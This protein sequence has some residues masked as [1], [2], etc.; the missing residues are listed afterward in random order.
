ALQTENPLLY[1]SMAVLAL[2]GPEPRVTLA[3]E[4]GRA[5][6]E[7]DPFLLPGLVDRLA[8]FALTD[9]QWTALVPPSPVDHVDLARHLESRGLLHE[10][11]VLYASALEGASAAEEP[12]IRWMLARLLLGVHRPA[13][14]MVQ[15]DA[16]LAKSSGNPEL[17]LVRAQALEALKAPGSLNAY[18]AAVAS[19]EGRSG[20]VF[21]TE[22]PRL[23]AIAAERLGR[24]AR[25]SPARY[26]RAL[27]QRLT[28][29]RRWEAARDEWERAGTDGPL[30]AQGE[31]SRGLA[32]EATGDPARALEAFRQAATLDPT[33]TAFRARLATRLWENDQYMQAIAEWQTIAGLEPGNVE[34]HLALA[35]AY[36]KA[37]DRGRALGEYRRVLV[38]APGHAE[39]RQSVARLSGIP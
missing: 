28:D 21:P 17:L 9:A 18:R 15:A 20:L 23:Q 5:A 26:R 4:A 10:A 14:A 16:A 24:D 34:A 32:L 33:R 30:D 12:V 19:A 8:P 37:G 3:L 2:A 22:S 7:R 6:A 27:A 31:F 35:R 11:R 29:E 1:R 38:L 39:A 25:I 13:E 36:L